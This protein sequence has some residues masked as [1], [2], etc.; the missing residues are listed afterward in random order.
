M[1]GINH[2]ACVPG[3]VS[4]RQLRFRQ[5]PLEPTFYSFKGWIVWA[6]DP[7]FTSDDSEADN[8]S[9]L[10]LEANLVDVDL[11]SLDCEGMGSSSAQ[12]I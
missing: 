3:F 8:H 1:M 11:L 6:A 2:L 7:I 10:G 9:C 5:L 4:R 12:S